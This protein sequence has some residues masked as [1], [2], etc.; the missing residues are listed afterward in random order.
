GWTVG[1]SV[2]IHYRWSTGHIDDTRKYAAELVALSP[3]VIFAPGALAL[4]RC[5]R[6][7]AAYR[8]CS[9]S[10]LIRSARVSSTAWPDRAASSPAWRDRAATSPALPDST[11]AS[12]RNGSSCLRRSRQT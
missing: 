1:Q 5:C 9:P 6:R 8:S 3:D 12:A 2:Q 11:T 10:S 7:L 4:G